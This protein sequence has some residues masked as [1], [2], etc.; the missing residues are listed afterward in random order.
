MGLRT[1]A[2]SAFAA[3]NPAGQP[4]LPRESGD[5]RRAANGGCAT[6]IDADIALWCEKVS[7][8]AA[9]S[10]IG[11]LNDGSEPGSGRI[12]TSFEGQ[13]DPKESVAIFW[14]TDWSTMSRCWRRAASRH[15]T[16]Q[17]SRRWWAGD[18]DEI[19]RRSGLP[20]ALEELLATGPFPWRREA[21]FFDCQHPGRRQK[22]GRTHQSFD[23]REAL[24]ARSF[25][26]SARAAGGGAR[27][28]ARQRTAWPCPP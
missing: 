3:T 12:Q 24:R 17:S 14:S 27:R 1:A 13:L 20:S 22:K 5:L 9:H 25:R 16:W 2:G 4:G 10:L 8:P 7:P 26:R 19:I 15:L 6:C 23:L 21:I 28:A 11:H 18:R